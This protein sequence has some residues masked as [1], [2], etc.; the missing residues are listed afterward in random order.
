MSEIMK[1][2]AILGASGYTGAEMIRLALRHPRL[3]IVALTGSSRAGQAV[4]AVHPALAGYDLPDIVRAE[5]VDWSDIDVAFACLPHGV[6]QETVSI[7]ADQVETV[8]DLSADYRLQDV[9]TYERYY[10]RSHD[11]AERLRGAVY[12]LTE[13]ARDE[14]PGA[15][16]VACP[17][18]FP[19][20]TLL[21][22]APFSDNKLIDMSD[23]RVTAL[24]GVSGAG[25][26]AL[27]AFSFSEINDSAHPYG[28]GGHRHAPEMDAFLE[29]LSGEDV[30]ISFVPQ[31]V[32][33]TRGMVAT[34]YVKLKG[35]VSEARDALEKCY[36][37]APFVEVLPAGDV[38]RTRNVRGSNLCRIGLY[39]DR[40][41]GRAILVSTIDNLTKGSSG[42]ALQNYNL[43]Q[44]W[45]ETLG[46]DMPPL[47]P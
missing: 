32:P 26:K 14:L 28:L 18:C 44:G 25:R 16:L 10:G 46:L 29:G 36:A 19:T 42:Q 2:A 9:E 5:D 20:C 13:W 38:P 33:I 11:D 30:E 21:A 23:I 24:T 45:E 8:I 41:E 6:S 40:Q 22:L 37:N 31:L 39:P 47:F 15:S 1:T 34:I 4:S 3:N 7:I 17:G 27:E 12:G 43:T 35:R